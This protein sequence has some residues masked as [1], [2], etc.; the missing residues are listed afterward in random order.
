MTRRGLSVVDQSWINMIEILT[1]T[2]ELPLDP[3]WAMTWVIDGYEPIQEIPQGLARLSSSGKYFNTPWNGKAVPLLTV[4]LSDSEIDAHLGELWLK[5]LGRGEYASQLK[6]GKTILTPKQ[7]G[8]KL[9]KKLLRKISFSKTCLVDENEDEDLQDDVLTLSETDVCYQKHQSKVLCNGDTI[10]KKGGGCVWS[11]NKCWT[12]EASYT[13][14]G[15]CQPV[16][17]DLGLW[18][19][20]LSIRDGDNTDG[21]QKIPFTVANCEA[22][23]LQIDWNGQFDD[24]PGRTNLPLVNPSDKITFK[25]GAWYFGMGDLVD[26]KK[27]ARTSTVNLWNA[28][29]NALRL[30]WESVDDGSITFR[31]LLNDPALLVKEDVGWWNKSLLLQDSTVLETSEDKIELSNLVVSAWMF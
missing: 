17:T 23:D 27:T 16:D 9:A 21:D 11:L 30:T 3:N 10:E 15:N 22:P 6:D 8:Y 4:E 19:I 25:G 26:L 7:Y 24:K 31:S 28:N 20:Q 18:N 1:M 14:P 29:K 5:N 12:K 2:R 13:L